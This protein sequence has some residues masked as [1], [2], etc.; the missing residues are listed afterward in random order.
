MNTPL[1]FRDQLISQKAIVS[2]M[3]Y[4]F[5]SVPGVSDCTYLNTPDYKDL[6][7]SAYNQLAA[8]SQLENSEL[9]QHFDVSRPFQGFELV[10]LVEEI[11]DHIHHSIEMMSG[12]VF[13]SSDL[14]LTQSEFE[15]LSGGVWT[16]SWSGSGWDI[17]AEQNNS[18]LIDEAWRQMLSASLS[19]DDLAVRFLRF[20]AKNSEQYSRHIHDID[21]SFDY[22]PD[23]NC[24]GQDTDD[25][26]SFWVAR[27]QTNDVIKFESE[28]AAC[29]YQRLYRSLVGL[30]PLTGEVNKD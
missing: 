19:G 18:L 27:Y 21:V 5:E 11:G 12:G 26:D 17:S 23:K 2:A 14:P 10:E 9:P 20:M 3:S 7:L 13:S 1:V 16:L 24:F 15:R 22:F 28:A 25:G 30:C 8:A 4:F 29:A 6:M